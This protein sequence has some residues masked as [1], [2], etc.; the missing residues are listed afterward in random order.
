MIIANLFTSHN[1]HLQV[2]EIKDFLHPYFSK[3]KTSVN[4]NIMPN[5]RGDSTTLSNLT[6]VNLK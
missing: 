1:I 2:S 3:G 6:E 4:S 5:L